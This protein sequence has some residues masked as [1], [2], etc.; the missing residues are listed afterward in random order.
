M[1]LIKIITKSFLVFALTSS[2]FSANSRYDENQGC[3]CCD[4][5]ISIVCE[6]LIDSEEGQSLSDEVIISNSI[7]GLK[8]NQPSDYRLEYYFP[9]L[10]HPVSLLNIAPPTYHGVK[11]SVRSQ[12]L[13]IW[14]YTW[15]RFNSRRIWSLLANQFFVG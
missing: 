1:N 5:D 14:S 15:S 4:Y 11:Y 13:L 12:V 9:N 7:K 10:N 2:L 6:C 8:I 3:C